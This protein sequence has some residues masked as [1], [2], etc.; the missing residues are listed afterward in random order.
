MVM[1]LSS[2]ELQYVEIISCSFSSSDSTLS[3][4]SLDMYVQS[5]WLGDVASLDPLQETFPSDDAIL[6]TMSFEDPPWL[7]DHRHSL[8]LLSHGAMTT[9]LGK[10]ASYVPSQPLQM[11]IL[12]HEVF[13]RGIWGILHKPCPSTS[14]LNQGLLKIF[15]LELL[16]LLRRSSFTL[17][18]SERFTKCLLGRM[19]K[20][21]VFI[22]VLWYKRYLCILVQ[23][24]FVNIYV[25]CTRERPLPLR[26]RLKSFSRKGLYTLSR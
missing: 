18:F 4:R 14:L 5:H 17:T 19:K 21:P 3:S 15:T 16:V 2:E 9:Y 20:C 12:T 24:Q 25:L 11:P 10:F 22:R 7:D 26:E 1:P 6:E 8:F 13:L 23:N